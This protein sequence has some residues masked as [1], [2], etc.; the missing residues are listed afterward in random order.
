MQIQEKQ[1]HHSDFHINNP[2]RKCWWEHRVKHSQ[3]WRNGYPRNEESQSQKQGTGIRGL[4]V[5]WETEGR[6]GWNCGQTRQVTQPIIAPFSSDVKSNTC[7][8]PGTKWFCP[9]CRGFC[10]FFCHY[11]VG[12]GGAYITVF[13]L[14]FWDHSESTLLSQSI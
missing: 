2:I 11:F 9:F 14:F 3:E 13:V 1:Q 10:I 5:D 6:A 8:C 12:G 4:E 7:F